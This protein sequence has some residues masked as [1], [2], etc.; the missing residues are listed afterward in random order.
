MP[1]KAWHTHEPRSSRT[2]CGLVLRKGLRIS[3]KHTTCKACL[4]LLPATERDRRLRQSEWAKMTTEERR[5]YREGYLLGHA[6]MTDLGLDDVEQHADE[7]LSG[8]Y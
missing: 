3:H 4:D 6:G 2:L 5:A 8:R 7:Y 1:S